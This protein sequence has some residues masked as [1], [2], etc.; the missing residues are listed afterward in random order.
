MPTVREATHSDIDRLIALES[1]L[2]VEDAGQH[3]PYADT[4]WPSREGRA[5]FERFIDAPDHLLIAACAE[6]HIVAFLAGYLSPSSPTRQPV[7]FA[8]LRSLFVDADHRR[9][10]AASA[11]TEHF[12]AWATEHGAVEAH[13]DSYAAN[14]AAQ[15]LYE[16]QG[17]A[18]RSISRVLPLRPS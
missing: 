7:T 2:F 3:E 16:R 4:T 1:A 8:T 10:G 18:M 12:V 5:D 17:F 9:S 11:L 15:R 6:D 14:E 13:V